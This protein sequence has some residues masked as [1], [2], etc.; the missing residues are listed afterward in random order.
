MIFLKRGRGPP[1]LFE[2]DVEH[3]AD[4]GA[5]II[6]NLEIIDSEWLELIIE[7]KEAGITIE[8][9]REYLRSTKSHNAAY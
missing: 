7:A 6:L 1:G 8:E 5:S 4:K 3:T 9:I 2:G